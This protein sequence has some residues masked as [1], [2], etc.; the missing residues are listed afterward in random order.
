MITCSARYSFKICDALAGCV[1]HDDAVKR[2]RCDVINDECMRAAYFL[3]DLIA[4]TVS[5]LK[6]VLEQDSVEPL[7]Q[8]GQPLEQEGTLSLCYYY[9]Y[10]LLCFVPSVQ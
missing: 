8:D 6:T 7:N 5:R 10:L 9:Y 1:D 4:M 3:R 2:Y